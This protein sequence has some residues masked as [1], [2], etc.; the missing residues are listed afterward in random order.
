MPGEVRVTTEDL[1]V[2]ASHVDMHADNLRLRHGT[3]DGQLE[4]AQPGLPAGSAAALSGA[5]TKWQQDTTHQYTRMIDHS[6]GLRSGAAS[7]AEVDDRSA[8]NLGA[9]GTSVPPLDLGL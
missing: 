4:A 9:A 2:S 8:E 7:Y 6:N 3:A 1:K 5:V